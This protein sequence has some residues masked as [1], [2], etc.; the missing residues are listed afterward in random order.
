M[1]LML[2]SRQQMTSLAFMQCGSPDRHLVLKSMDMY[3]IDYIK[4]FWYLCGNLL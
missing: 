1:P 3:Y 2:I 4:D